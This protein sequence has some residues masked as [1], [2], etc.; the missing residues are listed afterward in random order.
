MNFVAFAMSPIGSLSE[1]AGYS[2]TGQVTRD[3]RANAVF[4]T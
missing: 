3:T 1:V 2:A 4:H